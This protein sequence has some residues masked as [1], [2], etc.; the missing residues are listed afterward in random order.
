MPYG[1][2]RCP[3]SQESLCVALASRQCHKY[4]HYHGIWGIDQ[5]CDLEADPLESQNLLHS[6]EHQP[7]YPD[8]G[9]Q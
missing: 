4:I 5:L 8:K 2:C 9:N 6:T 1:F 3:V 7:L